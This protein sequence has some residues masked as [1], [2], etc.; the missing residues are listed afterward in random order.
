MV[1]ST[2][3]LTPLDEASLATFWVTTE[4]DR[5]VIYPRGDLCVATTPRLVSSMDAAIDAGFFDIVV[6]LVDV[7]LLSAAAVGALVK[8]ARRDRLRIAVRNPQPLP[9]K[10]LELTHTS[11]L[12]LE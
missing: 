7:K 9:R 6:D 3:D 8:A 4:G 5:V 1:S 12:L 2:T 11:W 10:V